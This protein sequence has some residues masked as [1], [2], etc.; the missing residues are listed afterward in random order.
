MTTIQGGAPSA[1]RRA[2]IE[3]MLADYP[4]LDDERLGD[5]ISWFRKEASALDV[6][7]I[8]SNPAIVQPYRRF[9]ADHI[10]PISGRDMLRGTLFAAAMILVVVLI[11]WRAI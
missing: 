1:D 2:Q 10:D 8:A 6:A 11:A 4:N 7:T 3:R 5:L 9:C